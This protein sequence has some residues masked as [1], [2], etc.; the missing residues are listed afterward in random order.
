MTD[1]EPAADPRRK[2]ALALLEAGDAAAAAP[3]LQSLLTEMPQDVVLRANLGV[4]LHRTGDIPGAIAAFRDVAAVRPELAAVQANLATLLA[5]QGDNLGAIAAFEAAL[6]REPTQVDWLCRL[7]ELRVK[8]GDD[9]TAEILFERAL[10]LQ[11]D[12]MAALVGRAEL[13]FR[14][15][16]HAE[17][18]LDFNRILTRAPD[19]AAAWNA[20]GLIASA[21]NQQDAALTCFRRA[22]AAEPDLAPVLVNLG[23]ALIG[24]HAL[25]EAIDVMAHAVD[26]DPNSLAGYLNLSVA[27]INQ[28][29]PR[30]AAIAAGRAVELAPNDSGP[31]SNLL[32]ALQ[33]DPDRDA[34]TRTKQALEWGAKAAKVRRVALPPRDRDPDRKLRIAYLSGDFRAH[35]VGLYLL[36]VLPHHDRSR[37]HVTCYVNQKVGDPVTLALQ[38]SADSWVSAMEL[39]DAALAQR[40]ATDG[41]DILID[42]SGHTA[43]GRLGALARRPA[44]VQATWIGYFATTGLPTMDWI[45]ADA[46]LLPPDEVNQYSERPLLLPDT[47]VTFAPPPDSPAPSRPPLLERGHV[48]FGCFNNAAKIGPTVMALWAQIMNAVPDARLALRTGAFGDRG[49]VVRFQ[50]LFAAAGIDPARIDFAGHASRHDLLAAYNGIDIALDPFPFNGGITTVE[51]LWMGVP[52]VSR[53][54]DRYC[55][56]HSESSLVSL[57]LGD[58]VASD[59]AGYVATALALARDPARLEALRRD[60]RARFARSTLGDNPRFVRDLEAALRFAWQD[61]CRQPERAAG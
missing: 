54:G 59:S 27:L 13:R 42:L 24:R 19:T 43:A 6:V 34:A 53:K 32:A 55:G 5:Q 25:T 52:V 41:I 33:Y 21:R 29:R 7:G 10:E 39:D 20:L 8:R 18:E 17:A 40:I 23:S 49:T 44:P 28:G 60:M 4:A 16:R 51:A 45:I 36:G 47:Y 12:S 38:K 46:R 48:T 9:A 50:N 58:L 56:H 15:G 31:G 22:V 30:E 14:T 35:P 2:Q 1:A 3:L 26:R 57:G 37:F 61:W 11:P